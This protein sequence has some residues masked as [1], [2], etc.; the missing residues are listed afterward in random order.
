MYLPAIVMVGYYFEKRRAFATGVAV[1][2]SGIGAFIFAPL[3]QHLLSVYGWQGTTWIIAGLVLNGVVIGALFR[4]LEVTPQ[5]APPENKIPVDGAVPGPSEVTKLKLQHGVVVNGAKTARSEK[6]QGTTTYSLQDLSTGNSQEQNP[7]QQ[8]YCRSMNDLY[9]SGSPA[10]TRTAEDLKRPM[11]RKDI[12][13]SGSLHHLAEY[14]SNPDVTSYV[15]SV[16]SVPETASSDEQGLWGC[17][18]RQCH[19][20]TDTLKNMMDFSLLKNPVF[21]IYG[22]SCFLCM[23]GQLSKSD[24]NKTYT[25]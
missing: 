17:C 20:F 22:F 24:C 11:Y 5:A 7:S 1:C 19:A 23:G 3:S 10:A 2:G 12:F 9:T 14:Q 4:P 16:T 15:R 13:Y 18:R 8:L 6:D 21:C 25:K